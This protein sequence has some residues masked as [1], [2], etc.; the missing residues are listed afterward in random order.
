MPGIEQPALSRLE[1]AQADILRLANY[2]K[3]VYEHGTSVENDR[4]GKDLLAHQSIALEHGLA[5]EADEADD[6]FD[7]ALRITVKSIEGSYNIPSK[8]YDRTSIV[9]GLNDPRANLE[10][11][12]TRREIELD[13]DLDLGPDIHPHGVHYSVAF[14]KIPKA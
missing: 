10:M 13:E 7:S 5:I 8:R 4:L 1:Q 12:I 2:A 9:L 14:D 6:A 11:V 3:F